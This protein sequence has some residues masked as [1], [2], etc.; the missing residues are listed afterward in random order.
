MGCLAASEYHSSMDLET[1]RLRSDNC[2]A[3]RWS[4]KAQFGFEDTRYLYGSH[5]RQDRKAL[6]GIEAKKGEEK[7]PSQQK[8]ERRSAHSMDV[9]PAFEYDYQQIKER[10]L[11]LTPSFTIYFGSRYRA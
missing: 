5:N 6:G 9:V 3:R 8:D 7:D 11:I 10:Y 2:S 4:T 1:C